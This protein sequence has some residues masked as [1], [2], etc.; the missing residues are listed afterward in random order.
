LRLLIDENVSPEIAFSLRESGHDIKNVSDCCKGCQDEK[1]AEIAINEKRTIVT[2]DL[3]FGELYHHLGV[4]SVV[5][6]L[7]SRDPIIV[8]KHLADFFRKTDKRSKKQT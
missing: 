7:R 6:R 5:L 3:D 1:I 4:S 2:F 8:A